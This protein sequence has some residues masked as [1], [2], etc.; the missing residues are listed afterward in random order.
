MATILII[1]DDADI[2]YLLKKFLVKHGYEVLESL[3][4]NKALDILSQVKVDVVLCDYRLGDTDGKTMIG[5]IRQIQWVPVIII[6]GHNDLKIAVETMK[7]GA[8]DFVLKPLIPEEILRTVKAA[9]DNP[10]MAY[11]NSAAMRA[12]NEAIAAKKAKATGT[13]GY[14]F[15]DSPT[16][17][18]ILKQ[19]SLVAPTDFSVIIYGES[20]SGKEAIA[21][22]I[23]KRSKRSEFPFIA[24]DC[25]ALSKELAGS[26]LFG[27]ERGSFTGAVNQKTGSFELANGGTLFL[28]EI[29]NLSYDI[30]VSLLRVV[31]ERKLRRVGGTK[32]ISLDVRIIIAS[33]EKLWN[34]TQTGKFREDLFHRFNE[35]TIQVPPLRERKDDIMLFAE[36]FLEL[37]NRDLEKNIK[38]F[39]P[40]VK[41]LFRN[42]AWPGNLRELKNVV[43]RAALLTD[44]A[45]V[46]DYSLPT[47]LNNFTKMEFE[48]A[49]A[50]ES[51]P[52]SDGSDK[53]E[54]V[55]KPV[56][57]HSSLRV[58]SIDHEYE[59]IVKTLKEVNFNKT[60]AAKA[61]NIDRKTLYNKLALYRE[62]IQGKDDDDGTQEKSI[63]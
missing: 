18:H 36:H 24:I 52:S 51:V 46:E 28:D 29:S 15:G 60:K 45:W 63:G 35:F 33:N 22:E 49:E 50:Y 56:A 58:A 40:T 27:H 10:R 8:F 19:I 44:S 59:L 61:L 34:A 57:H 20:G 37:A 23:H 47:E 43:K 1:D 3:R 53:M 55:A 11:D 9:L 39:T 26:E 42:Y 48:K 16:F 41:T 38:G 12:G 17:V 21:Q 2:C 7:V 31:Q 13:S 32:D 14:I 4:A 6:T 5:K 30:Q 25:G 62:L 54:K